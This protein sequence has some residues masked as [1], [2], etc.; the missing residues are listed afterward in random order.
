MRG[1]SCK[2]LWIDNATRSH[3]ETVPR[4]RFAG[5]SLETKGSVNCG[6]VLVVDGS[7]RK[8]GSGKPR[9]RKSSSSS[10]G[11]IGDS[12]KGIRAGSEGPSSRKEWNTFSRWDRSGYIRENCIDPLILLPSKNGAA[13]A[14]TSGRSSGETQSFVILALT[15]VSEDDA[16]PANSA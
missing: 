13:S 15:G 4:R 3:V 5:L 2:P 6:Q 8:G 11:G 9:G 7:G 10:K 16:H 12:N 1:E 14:G